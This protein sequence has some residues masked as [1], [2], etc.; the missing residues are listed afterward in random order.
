MSSGHFASWDIT[1]GLLREGSKLEGQIARHSAENQI[2]SDTFTKRFQENTGVSGI[3]L[4]EN[5]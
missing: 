5:L 4:T 2:Y 1:V 3:F